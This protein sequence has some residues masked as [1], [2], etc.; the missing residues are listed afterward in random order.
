MT[1]RWRTLAAWIA[2]ALAYASFPTT[3]RAQDDDAADYEEPAEEAGDGASEGGDD[4][5]AFEASLAQSEA[6]PGDA[7]WERP[8]LMVVPARDTPEQVVSEMKRLLATAGELVDESGYVREA[9][10]RGLPSDTAEALAAVL[11]EL[12]PE[13]DLVVIVGVNRP[14]RATLVTLRYLDRFGLEMLE[15]AHSIRGG[16]P[17]EESA[18]RVLSETRLALAVITRPPGGLAQVE[19]GIAPGEITPGLAVH[20]GIEAGGGF[21]TREFEVPPNIGGVLALG[22]AIFPTIALALGIDIEPTA[23]GQLSIGARLEYQ[24][25]VGLVTTDNRVDGSTRETGSRSQHLM[26]GLSLLY[27]L[28]AALDTVSLGVAAGWS[29]LS[30]TSEAPVSLPDY[31]LQGPYLQLGVVVPLAD[32][33]VT[34]ELWPEARWIVDVGSLAGLGVS[35]SGAAVGGSARVR[36]RLLPEL[37]AELAYRE[38]HSFLAAERGGGR[39]VER[40]VTARVI[41]RP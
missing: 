26:A 5:A 36:L 25:S 14:E 9:R 7:A 29:A 38:S 8:S 31:T 40:F 22:T 6:A 13:V 27:R 16:L 24:T 10:A 19:G 33:L 37:F 20:V 35:S 12:H 21:G 17:T 41:Y 11:S 1:R 3:L 32:R 15:E 30:F 39:D 28:D 34:L 4:D 2:L 18:A 23:R